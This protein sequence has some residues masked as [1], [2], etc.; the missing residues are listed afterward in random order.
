MAGSGLG[1]AREA[2]L[3]KFLVRWI[4]ANARKRPSEVGGL[5]VI[6]AIYSLAAAVQNGEISDRETLYMYR[7]FRIGF[8][9][10]AE[11]LDWLDEKYG[12]PFQRR[13]S[14]QHVE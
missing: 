9:D 4:R 6:S 1:A 12:S 8:A 5:E 13:R 2:M 3:M 10:I 7:L 14:N 11:Y